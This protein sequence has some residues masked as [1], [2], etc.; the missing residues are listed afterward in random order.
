LND[1]FALKGETIGD[2]LSPS[3]L[4][5]VEHQT[6]IQHLI[7]RRPYQISVYQLSKY[8][9]LKKLFEQDNKRIQA[10]STNE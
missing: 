6:H 1:V 7:I 4:F 2:V 3:G 5:P 9:T 8:Y 10:T